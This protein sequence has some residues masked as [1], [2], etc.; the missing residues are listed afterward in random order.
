MKSQI[1][2][3]KGTKTNASK[4][5][6]FMLFWLSPMLAKNQENASG[7]C[8]NPWSKLGV[9]FLP[10]YKYVVENLVFSVLFFYQQKLIMYD[11]FGGKRRLF[12]EASRKLLNILY[13]VAFV[14]LI[15]LKC[16]LIQLSNRF[17]SQ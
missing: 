13:L 6:L 1:L 12:K 7:I 2:S 16:K 14:C 15:L 17:F 9:F 4:G 10:F 5:N 8:R 3:A 11:F